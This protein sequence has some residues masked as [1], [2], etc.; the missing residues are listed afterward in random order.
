[1]DEYRACVALQEEIWGRGFSER[2]PV[3]ILKVTQEL[4]G[5][6]AG[7]FARDGH[8]DGFVFGMTGLDREGTLVHWSDMLAVRPE[9]EGS[10]LGTDLKAFQRDTV[11]ER[12]VRWMRWSFDPLR[13][14]NA[15]LNLNKLGATVT[16]YRRDMYGDTASRLHAGVGTDRFVASWDL[17]APWRERPRP[18][19]PEAGGQ[20]RGATVGETLVDRET[21]HGPP[22]VLECAL[23]V[24]RTGPLPRPVGAGLEIRT[25]RVG[26]P[27]PVD[28]GRVIHEAPGLAAE[29]RSV[30]RTVFEHYF[31]L[32][33]EARALR[34]AEDLA[35]YVLVESRGS[36]RFGGGGAPEQGEELEGGTP[37]DAEENG[38]REPGS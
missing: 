4:G 8:L 27:V 30:T 33:Y 9:A 18:G 21:S 37:H 6:A 22:E 7:A 20:A 29:W 28:I 26:V 24:D 23:R 36:R 12:G 13:A 38:E 11:R 15:H 35:T 14:R 1:M 10:G 31:A 2:V 16:E 3:A 5:V 17:A 34:R 25:S 32:G 19:R